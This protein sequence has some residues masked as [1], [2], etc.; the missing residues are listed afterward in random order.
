M[1]A[2]AIDL[3]NVSYGYTPVKVV[4]RR[5]NLSFEQST[6]TAIIGK[7]GSG[8]STLLEIINGMIKPDEGEVRLHGIPV[9]YANVYTLR[10]KIGYVVQHIGLFPHMSVSENI[11]I[12]GRILKKP[13]QE[14]EDR[15]RYL[16]DMVQLPVAYLNKYPHELSGGEQQRA[17][18]CRALL[19]KP[20]VLLMDEPFA[21][22]DNDTK[23]SIYDH[24]LDIQKKES[25]TI[26]LVTHDWDETAALADNF[27]WIE[28]GEVKARG[29]KTDLVKLR[30][31]Y[32]SSP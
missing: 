17:G 30:D 4:L 23:R 29:G 9:D 1:D 25:R 28:N 16:I 6:I 14:I 24:L 19:L 31:D 21:S 7:S 2:N 11:S 20:P 12:L 22:L 5:I 27:I 13:G 10:L 18:I 15:I 8:K 3:L 26:V 32:F